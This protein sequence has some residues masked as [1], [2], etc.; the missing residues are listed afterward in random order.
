MKKPQ[1][2]T[3][4]ENLSSYSS[5]KSEKMLLV[6]KV[7]ELEEEIRRLKQ[8]LRLQ[9]R[10]QINKSSTKTLKEDFKDSCHARK[11]KLTLDLKANRV[12]YFF[13]SQKEKKYRRIDFKMEVNP[14][15]LYGRTDQLVRDIADW[16]STTTGLT[17]RE[18]SPT[19]ADTYTS[20][21]S[22]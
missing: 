7:A 22:S 20:K 19:T 12:R 21:T 16:S 10:P 14:E 8:E 2:Q 18:A 15:T 11:I 6:L 9:T 17:I 3:Y 1:I 4:M 13:K 5:E